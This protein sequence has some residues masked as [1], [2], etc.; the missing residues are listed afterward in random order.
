M[1][2]EGRGEE[3]ERRGGDGRRGER[4][5]GRREGRGGEVKEDEATVSCMLHRC[6]GHTL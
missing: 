4:R 2:G 5:G 1:G 6:T 3:G